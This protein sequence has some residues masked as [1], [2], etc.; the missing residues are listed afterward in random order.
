MAELQDF[1]NEANE[2]IFN[3]LITFDPMTFEAWVIISQADV[4]RLG[5]SNEELVASLVKQYGKNIN[6][7]IGHPVI[8]NKDDY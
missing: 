6:I 2:R 5:L 4:D 8:F 3:P 1:N 7:C